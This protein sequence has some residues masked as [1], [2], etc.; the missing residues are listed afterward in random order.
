MEHGLIDAIIS[1][2]DMKAKLIGYMD[3]LTAGKKAAAS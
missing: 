3:F 1:R 2:N